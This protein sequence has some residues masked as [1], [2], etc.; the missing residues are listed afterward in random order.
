MGKKNRFCLIIA[1]LFLSPLTS[2]AQWVKMFDTNGLV[3][4]FATYDSLI[5]AGTER[6]GVLLSVDNGEYW[7]AV[8]KGLTDLT[9]NALVFCDSNLFA[10]TR[11][12]GVFISSDYG[13][14]WTYIDIG[15]SDVTI[16]PM[17]VIEKNIYAATYHQ[18]SN[19]GRV[20]FS[21]DNG[22]TWNILTSLSTS[23]PVW[24]F[25]VKDSNLIAGTNLDGIFISSDCGSSWRHTSFSKPYV[26]ALVYQG[27]N[28]FAGTTGNGVFLS[29]DSGMSWKPVNNGLINLN[30]SDFAIHQSI[31][32]ASTQGN[33]VFYS[34]NNGTSWIADT[35][36]LED[37]IVWSLVT[38]D[39]YIFAGA[40]G[41]IWRQP[42][43]EVVIGVRDPKNYTSQSIELQQNY[44]N[45][46][47][48]TT[49]INYTLANPSFIIL[50]IYDLSGREIQ[51]LEKG[52]RTS[53][54]H[55]VLF[56][57][58]HLPSGIYFYQL[59]ADNSVKT[60]KLILLK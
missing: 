55:S 46:F 10:G 21:T 50:R 35:L 6:H 48:P 58:D 22:M 25:A 17:A 37:P 33:G 44:P 42:L 16:N 47:N 1:L 2:N 5:F 39:K 9:I 27:I 20:C 59:T 18:P 53:G 15:L 30:V 19:I 43:S 41:G 24:S 34:F 49:T 12:S 7:T 31:I 13:T 14:N 29:S 60:K 26:T 54:R 56:Q 8:N 32:F 45:P 36:G 52:F 11:N 23:D 57:G 51:I 40:Y 4:C 38:N 28:I 3:L